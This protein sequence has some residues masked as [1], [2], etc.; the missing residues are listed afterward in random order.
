ME[1]AR[2]ANK[3]PIED[4]APSIR[5]W[6]PPTPFDEVNLPDFPVD[7]LPEPV[8]AFVEALAETTQTPLEMGGL[9]SLGVLAMAFQRRHSVEVN[10]DWREPLSL[11]TVAVAPPAD[12]KSSVIAAVTKPAI[13]WEAR[14]REIEAAEV[15][16]NQTE[17][18]LLEKSLEAAK[19]SAAKGKGGYAE[20]RAEALDLSQQLAEFKDLHMTR[21]LVD[22][23]IT[24]L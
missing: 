12:R 14:Q 19:N 9:L 18:A 2:Q 7:T 23:C 11:Y 17:R 21:I 24:I 1:D 4:N 10:S 20:K 3:P 8:A 5:E 22:D 13:E 16:Q 6:E 15:A